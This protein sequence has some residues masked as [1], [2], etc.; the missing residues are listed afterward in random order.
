M[1][2]KKT[3]LK[4]KHSS[5]NNGFREWMREVNRIVETKI[6]LPLSDLPDEDFNYKYTECSYTPKQMA[7]EM[8][9]D[10]YGFLNLMMPFQL[11]E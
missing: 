2:T 3:S 9:D 6:G 1:S 7:Y 8:I 4:R 11:V 5:E 10:Y